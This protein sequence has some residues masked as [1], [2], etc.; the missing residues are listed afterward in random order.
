[1]ITWCAV[2]FSTFV[3]SSSPYLR[4]SPPLFSTLVCE[5]EPDGMKGPV[6]EALEVTLS[7]LRLRAES[8]LVCFW[9][10]GV[11]IRLSYE[12]LLS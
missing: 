8:V 3:S 4:L 9:R 6:L 7:S 5:P 12:E 1:V 2:T 10:F 11:I